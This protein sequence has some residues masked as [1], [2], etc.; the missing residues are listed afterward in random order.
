MSKEKKVLGKGLEI[1]FSSQPQ[2]EAVTEISAQEQEL[3]ETEQKT[4]FVDVDKIS[5]NPFQPR[6]EFDEPTLKELADSIK[7]KGV[8]Q[9]ITIRKLENGNYELIAGER[10]LRASRLAGLKQIPAYVLDVTSKEDLLEISLIENIQRKDL[11]AMEVAHGYRRLIEEC[12]LTQEEV[13]DKV[14]KSRS[15]VTNYL[16]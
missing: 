9:A 1:L 2:T 6:E 11:N 12:A 16:R 3:K 5:T 15:V 7:Q 13:A 4:L 14:S 10:R 8:I